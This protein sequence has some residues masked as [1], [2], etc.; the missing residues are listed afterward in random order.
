VPYQSQAPGFF[1]VSKAE[2]EQRH[3]VFL[4]FSAKISTGSSTPS[5]LP[6]HGR[7]WFLNRRFVFSLFPSDSFSTWANGKSKKQALIVRPVWA[8]LVHG[9]HSSLSFATLLRDIIHGTTRYCAVEVEAQTRTLTGKGLHQQ[10]NSETHTAHGHF[11]TSTPSDP[12]WDVHGPGSRSTIGF[13]TWSNA[14][15]KRALLWVAYVEPGTACSFSAKLLTGH[16]G[17]HEHGDDA[18]TSKLVTR[19]DHGTLTEQSTT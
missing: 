16:D 4:P 8:S 1:G 15:S 7:F 17:K 5:P 9:K 3:G 14:A 10:W 11:S 13:S 12:F 6:G 18:T 19:P 2:V